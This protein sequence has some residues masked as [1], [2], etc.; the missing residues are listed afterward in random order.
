MRISR[1]QTPNKQGVAV[2]E[3]ASNKGIGSYDKG[4]LCGILSEPTEIPDLDKARFA[5]GLNMF[6][7][8]ELWINHKSKL[9]YSICWSPRNT[10]DIDSKKIVPTLNADTLAQIPQTQSYQDLA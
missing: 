2:V 7:K 8:C 9:F 1:L 10:K 6:W 5:Y 4:L 3:M